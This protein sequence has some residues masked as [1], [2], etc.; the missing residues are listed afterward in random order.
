MSRPRSQAVQ[1]DLGGNLLRDDYREPSSGS[2]LEE[3]L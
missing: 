2:R 3:G 1:R